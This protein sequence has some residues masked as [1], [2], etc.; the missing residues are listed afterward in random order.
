MPM[1][2][3][4]ILAF[5]ASLRKGSYSMMVQNSLP[6]LAPEGAEVAAFAL[7]GIPA[8]NQDLEASMPAKVLEFKAATVGADAVVIVTPE[9]NYSM[10]G[11]LKN[12]I[13]WASRPY[14][15]NSLD[16]KPAAIISTSPGAL[17]GSRANYHLR[18]SFIFLNVRTF[19]KPE[20]I[21]PQDAPEGKG[22]RAVR[23]K[24]R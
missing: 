7:D 19:N 11:Y 14:G 10:P 1:A 4:R 24:D 9:Y 12:A 23:R 15:S 13:D 20:A 22:R 16:G 17:G 18:Q 3:I 21:I 6:A 2:K 5:G 8:F